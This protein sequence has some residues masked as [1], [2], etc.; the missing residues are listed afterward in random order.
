MLDE[1]Y[2]YCSDR[3][4]TVKYTNFSVDRTKRA[5]TGYSVNLNDSTYQY[6]LTRGIKLFELT[7]HLG[8]VVA[9]ITDGSNPATSG[10]AGIITRFV[11]IGVS[12]ADYSP[13]GSPLTLRNS[14]V[15]RYR[16]GFNGKEL[17][18]E[19]SGNGNELYYGMR[20]Y[21]QRTGRFLS[22]DLLTSKYPMLTPYQYASNSPIQNIDLNGLEGVGANL[23][24]YL[25][26]AHLQRVNNESIILKLQHPTWSSLRLFA[27][28]SLNVTTGYPHDILDV[29]G[30]VPAFGEPAD[31]INGVLYTL[32]GDKG[33][34]TLSFAGMVPLAGVG[35]TGLK[36][37]KN[38]LKLSDNAFHSASGL[39]FKT[40]S[41][42]GNRLAHV[43]E[44]TADDL[45]KFKHG[46]FDLGDKLIENID[47]AYSKVQSVKWNKKLSVGESETIDGITRSI[48][49]EKSGI[50]SENYVVDMGKKVGYEGGSAG[51]REAL[52]KIK[53]SVEKGTS[54][55]L[56]AFPTK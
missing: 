54:D 36:W 5:I 24:P 39:V 26:S 23:R 20:V 25:F 8:N 22:V 12:R 52:N 46:V 56:T 44:H 19:V 4:G 13:F 35:A 38:V 55:V 18:N 30:L 31:L 51:S 48:R 45:G 37:A 10:G 42:H 3:V 2:I 49:K 43:L 9:T 53:I 15:S 14:N 21:D 1:H 28:A 17:D 33:N 11:A 7:N 47:D 32:E 34:A 29:A 16:Y 41:K 50:I 40:G 27:K 6:S